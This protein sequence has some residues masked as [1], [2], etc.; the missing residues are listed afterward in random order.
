MKTSRA[1]K[2]I[3]STMIAILVLL[4]IS[5]FWLGSL[6][7]VPVLAMCGGMIVFIGLWIEREADEE[8]KREHRNNFVKII[9]DLKLKSKIGWWILMIGIGVEIA[10]AAGMSFN[11][12]LETNKFLHDVNRIDPNNLPVLSMNAF[13]MLRVRGNTFPDLKQWAGIPISTNWGSKISTAT[14]CGDNPHS[15]LSWS[16]PT[17]VADDFGIGTGFPDSREYFLNFHM[18]SVSAAMNLPTRSASK[19][20]DAVHLISIDLRF[21]PPQSDILGG[22]AF[23]VVNNSLWKLFRIY[24][25]KDTQNP[26]PTKEQAEMLPKIPLYPVLQMTLK[27][28]YSAVANAKMQMVEPG[29]LT[30]FTNSEVVPIEGGFFFADFQVIGT[31]VP[32]GKFDPNW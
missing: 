16:I 12:A 18:E 6:A 20:L 5:S 23:V 2:A 3:A 10:M 1:A 15:V 28:S 21:L 24:P 29:K 32:N 9:S 22:Y 27:G 4:L 11:D 17:M 30:L 25:Q 31:N 14:L 26:F 19:S 8:E 13:V 7:I